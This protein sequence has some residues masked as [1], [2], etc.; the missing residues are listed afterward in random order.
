[1]FSGMNVLFN[2]LVVNNWTTQS[3]GLECATG[4]K[5]LVRLYLL[6]FNILGVVV[7]SNIVTSFV[8]NAFFQ[9]LATIGKGEM[10]EHIGGE[11]IISGKKALFDASKITGTKTGLRETNF[12]AQMIPKHRDVELDEREA[13]HRLFSSASEGSG[14]QDS[15]RN[16]A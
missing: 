2:M 16:T 12:F 11:A 14:V 10:D 15:V 8:I 1:M 7:I 4:S 9:Q 13:L 3:S 6:A 5:W